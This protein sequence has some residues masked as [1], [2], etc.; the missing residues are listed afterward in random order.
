MLP[1]QLKE[2]YGLAIN[3]PESTIGF[4]RHYGW[5]YTVALPKD[6]DP[7]DTEQGLTITQDENI[8]DAIFSEY[9]TLVSNRNAG[10][11]PM[12]MKGVTILA[13]DPRG[14]PVQV[15]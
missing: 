6:A 4:Y 14:T 7:R 9:V 15:L 2:A 1:S 11:T 13:Y 10:R 8:A 5:L 12:A 3:G